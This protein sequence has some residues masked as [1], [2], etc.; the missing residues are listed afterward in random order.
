MSSEHDKEKGRWMN[1]KVGLWID[2]REAVTVFL[3]S[4]KEERRVI[5]A[6]SL[7]DHV[8]WNTWGV[9]DDSAYYNLL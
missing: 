8:K 1:R 4:H 6:R 2:N 5:A 9:T 7:R 3:A